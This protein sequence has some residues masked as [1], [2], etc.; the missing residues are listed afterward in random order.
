M[1]SGSLEPFFRPED[2][3]KGRQN[4]IY[5]EMFSILVSFLSSNSGLKR[6]ETARCLLFNIIAAILFTD[7]LLAEEIVIGAFSNS[8][9]SG[10]EQKEFKGTTSYS[11]TEVQGLMVLR[12]QSA[13][14]ASALVREKRVNLSEFPYLNWNWRVELKLDSKNER[15]KSG[16]DYAARIYVIF[17]AGIFPWQLKAVNYVWASQMEKGEI[18]ENAFAG[19]NAMMIA[20]RNH[21]D[22]TSI[23]L[24]EKRNIKNDLK[25]M[26]GFEVDW[27]DG[28]AIMTDTDNSG[29]LAETYYGDIFFSTQ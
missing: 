6:F 4:I 18:W 10:W 29:G 14:S 15:R 23:W 5:N 11:L 22:S 1:T 13:D 20:L 24:S 27:I 16:D 21:E 17:D 28:V 2:V 8:D 3:W 12:A 7:E 9:L 19:K 26:F 25:E